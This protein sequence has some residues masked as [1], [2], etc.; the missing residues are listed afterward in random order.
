MIH[1]AFATLS[2]LKESEV[3]NL[4]CIGLKKGRVIVDGTLL[5]GQD[6]KYIKYI[7]AAEEVPSTVVHK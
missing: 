4:R 6:I 5:D 7:I 2:G 1:F 3:S